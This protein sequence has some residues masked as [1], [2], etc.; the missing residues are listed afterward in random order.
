VFQI[1]SGQEWPLVSTLCFFTAIVSIFL[2]NV[3]TVLLMTPVT[4]R[5]C[6]VMQLNPVPVL[7]A[8]V[9]FSNIGGA[10][11]PVGDPPN[12]IIASNRDV[13]NAVRIQAQR[14]FNIRLSLPSPRGH[15]A[16]PPHP[17]SHPFIRSSFFGNY[18]AYNNRPFS[19]KVSMKMPAFSSLPGDK[20]D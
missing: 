18:G 7:T 4:I 19:N 1:T 15:P 3:T 12:V 16:T 2:D 10:M 5:L 20:S 9:I 17:L 6:E 13:V 11:T 14:I 8:M